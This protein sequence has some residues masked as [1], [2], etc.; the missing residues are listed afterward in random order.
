MSVLLMEGVVVNN[1]GFLTISG[2]LLV[3]LPSNLEDL[4]R[5]RLAWLTLS[6]G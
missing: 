3:S 1:F 5:S 6:G 4:G 2:I